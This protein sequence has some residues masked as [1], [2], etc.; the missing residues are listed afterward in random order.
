MKKVTLKNIDKVLA[1]L[2]EYCKD[3][4]KVFG[5]E[6]CSELNTFFDELLVQDFFGTEGQLDP[7]GDHRNL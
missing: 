1:K 2:I 7:R 4:P 5:M 6:M 3:D